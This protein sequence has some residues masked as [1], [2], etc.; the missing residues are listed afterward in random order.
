MRDLHLAPNVIMDGLFNCF[1]ILK[2]K[3][4]SD[5]TIIGRIKVGFDSLDYQFCED[6]INVSKRTLHNHIGRITQL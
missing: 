6:K 3:Q 5:K 2:L 4:H 1:E